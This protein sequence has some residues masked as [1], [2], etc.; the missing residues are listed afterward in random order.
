MDGKS[1]QSMCLWVWNQFL[2]ETK[3]RGT[4]ENLTLEPSNKSRTDRHQNDES[5]DFLNKW[6]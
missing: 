2:N 1:V 6:S 5:P 3:N 4:V